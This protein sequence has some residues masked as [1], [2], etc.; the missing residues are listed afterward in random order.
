MCSL[1]TLAPSISTQRSQSA[2]RRGFHRAAQ[3]PLGSLGASSLS[4]RQPNPDHFTGENGGNR[5]RDKSQPS[6]QRSLRPW[7]P[8]FCPVKFFGVGM[9]S[10]FPPLP[11]VEVQV[12]KSY[13]QENCILGDSGAVLPQDGAWEKW[14]A[15][16]EQPV[17]NRNAELTT[18][19]QRHE[20]KPAGESPLCLGVFVVQWIPSV[21][22][23]V[24]NMFVRISE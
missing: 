5:E 14:F 11:P 1:G 8:W 13:A 12:R 3:P 20:G 21:A 2:R 18:K 23:V 22:A 4:R 7:F 24:T 9:P 16:G 10:L 6:E 19:A 17:S 15:C